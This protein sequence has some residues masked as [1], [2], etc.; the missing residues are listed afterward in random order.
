[1]KYTGNGSSGQN[2]GHGLSSAPEFI[3]IKNTTTAQNWVVYNTITNLG[4]SSLDYGYLSLNYAFNYSG[5]SGLSYPTSTVFNVGTSSFDNSNNDVFIAYC[6]HSVN[7]YQKIGSYTSNA[8]V[9]ISTGFEP[10]FLMIKYYGTTSNWWIMDTQR[11][12][13]ETGL[14]GGKLVKPFL[15]ANTS[16]AEQSVSAGSV[17]IMSDGFYPTN[18]F[19]SNGVIYLAIK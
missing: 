6:F 17:E 4:D 14:N 18:F 1:M 7:E 16:S 15:E 12:G 2:I 19:N 3:I 13:G 8:S 11:Y 9:K 5:N 10:R